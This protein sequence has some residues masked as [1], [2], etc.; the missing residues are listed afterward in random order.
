MF[1]LKELESLG[2]K[3][4][5]I[6]NTVKDVVQTL[7][8]DNL[9]ETDK[10]GAGNFLW[11]LPSKG[12]QNLIT[13]LES[14]KSTLME[15]KTQKKALAQFIENQA[16]EKPDSAERTQKLQD[17][18]KLTE[19]LKT[20]QKTKD[21]LKSCTKQYYDECCSNLKSAQDAANQHTD[22]IFMAKSFLQSKMP[23]LS[24][25]DFHSHFNVPPELD[26]I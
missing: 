18:K 10:I 19:A 20:A 1:N 9:V 17:L 24:S 6:S 11:S 12:R 13:R 15:Q 16:K 5:V 22:N 7:L 14:L 8:D 2:N 4:G 21:S 26:N 25:S 23:Q 3:V